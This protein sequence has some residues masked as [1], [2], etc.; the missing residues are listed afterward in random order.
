MIGVA[1]V[2]GLRENL[3][4]GLDRKE[5]R[6][7]S[8]RRRGADRFQEGAARGILG[9]HRAD[10][11]GGDDALVALFLA[12]GRHGIAA[13]RQRRMLVFGR[14]AMLA[15]D[16][17]GARKLAVGIERIVEGGHAAPLCHTGAAEV[18]FRR[19]PVIDSRPGL[20]WPGREKHARFMPLCL[21]SGHPSAGPPRSAARD[22]ATIRSRSRSTSGRPSRPRSSARGTC[23]R[24][25]P[26]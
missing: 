1:Q 10:H 14:G 19:D 9:K 3:G 12:L 2:T 23:S 13:Q 5:L 21:L 24:R 16:A 15:A 20:C 26:P 8:Q 6:D 7:R 4:R 11:R 25:A 22:R 17:A 18:P